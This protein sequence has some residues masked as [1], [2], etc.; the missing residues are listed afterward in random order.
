M[1]AEAVSRSWRR[2]PRLSV[3]GLVVLVL[4]VGSG[5]GWFVRGAR[6]Q[7]DAV[8][9][10]EETGGLAYYDW[11]STN[12]DVINGGGPPAPWW[13][14]ELIGID[15]FGHVD[16][17][18]YRGS[19]QSEAAIAAVGRLTR[20]RYLNMDHTL[21]T[22]ANLVHVADLTSLHDLFLSDDQ[23]TN[24]GMVHLGR[25]SNL[26]RLFLAGTSVT[27]AGMV[28]LGRLTNLS[29]LDL[30]QTRVSEVGRRKLQQALPNLKIDY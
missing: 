11:E 9:A 4:L 14:C 24:A 10:I 20:L 23:V 26:S 6:I 27:N 22:D 16:A 21:T 25:L 15:C 19:T 12:G 1:R 30:R 7:R 17:V 8:A 3:R 13:L 28:Q 5:I 18:W 2:V 29:Y